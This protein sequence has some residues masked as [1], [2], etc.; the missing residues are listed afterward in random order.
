MLASAMIEY[1]INAM[2]QHGDHEV[3]FVVQNDDGQIYILNPN[4]I[5]YVP[6][7]DRTDKPTLQ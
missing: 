6:T 5:A 1:L 4:L 3:R 2:K 7:E